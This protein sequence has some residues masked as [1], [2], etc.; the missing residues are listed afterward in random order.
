M[1]SI[2]V[3]GTGLMGR[4]HAENI[5]ALYPRARLA[6]VADVR[7]DAA[8]S[9]AEAL[10]C[11]WYSDPDELLARADVQAVVIVT[12]ADTHAS[13][14][15]AAAERGKDVLCEKPLALTV[16]DARAAVDAAGRAGVRLQ[17]GFMRRYDPPYREAY[18]AI[19]R[20]D[21]GKPVLFAAISRDAQPPPREYFDVPGAGDIFMDSGVHDFDL[22]RWLMHDEIETVSAAGAIV[23][24]HDLADVQPQDVG[25]VT[26]RYCNGAAGTIQLYRNAV[27]G[28]DIRTE[29]IGTEGTAQ[30]GDTRWRPLQMRWRNEIAHT[31][32]HHWLDRFAEAYRLEMADWVERMSTDRPSYVTGED[33]VR[34][35]ALAMAAQRACASGLPVKPE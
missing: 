11:D 1:L 18:E 34:A 21:I 3:I 27:Y 10:G 20:G 16:D 22:A 25:L 30:I 6:A 4:R 29:V 23:A 14:T 15:I 8:R 31:M 26:L 33:G 5:A 19:E 7:A 13:F 32:A 35:V 24:C 28:Y 2:G 12:R 17:V 9:V